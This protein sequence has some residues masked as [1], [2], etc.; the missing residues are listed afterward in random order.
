MQQPIRSHSHLVLHSLLLHFLI[1]MSSVSKNAA[2]SLGSGNAVILPSLV[3]SDPFHQTLNAAI[4][5][6]YIHGEGGQ[7]HYLLHWQ[8]LYLPPHQYHHRLTRAPGS[9]LETDNGIRKTDIF[10]MCVQHHVPS[11]ISLTL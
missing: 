10:A 9:L 2:P 6:F 1:F 4:V 3:V 8:S 7:P 11:R 5:D